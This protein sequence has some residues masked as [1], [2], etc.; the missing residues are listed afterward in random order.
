MI[1]RSTNTFA[2]ICIAKS[3]KENFSNLVYKLQTKNE[4]TKVTASE[5]INN[6]VTLQPVTTQ[7]TLSLHSYS[8]SL[9]KSPLLYLY[10]SFDSA[11][12]LSHIL[13]SSFKRNRV[14]LPELHLILEKFLEKLYEIRCLVTRTTIWI[15]R[16]SCKQ[17]AISKWTVKKSVQF[18]NLK[19]L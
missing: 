18:I 16:K 9:S 11:F 15:G 8:F 17:H 19:A 1:D 12:Y 7:Q 6:N 14:F 2:H 4:K 5:K 13:S 3:Q 10:V